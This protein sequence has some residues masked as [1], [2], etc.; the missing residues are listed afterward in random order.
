MVNDEEIGGIDDDR[1]ILVRLAPHQGR[2]LLIGAA[3]KR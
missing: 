2:S 1:G 3:P